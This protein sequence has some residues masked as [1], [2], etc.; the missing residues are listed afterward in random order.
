[1]GSSSEKGAPQTYLF[2]TATDPRQ[3]GF[4]AAE[5]DQFRGLQVQVES[6]DRVEP[7]VCKEHRREIWGI[8]PD[9]PMGRN[10]DKGTLSRLFNQPGNRGLLFQVTISTEH[11]S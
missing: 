11:V 6:V 3:P 7:S 9:R 8:P 4:T 10:V 1:M 5:C 2:I